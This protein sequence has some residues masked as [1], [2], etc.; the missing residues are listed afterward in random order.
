MLVI[1]EFW[2]KYIMISRLGVKKLP[3]SRMAI[4]EFDGKKLFHYVFSVSLC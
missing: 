4:S 1:S 2:P 3:N